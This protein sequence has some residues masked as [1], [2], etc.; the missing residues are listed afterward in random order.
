MEKVIEWDSQGHVRI[1][2]LSS[3]RSVIIVWTLRIATSWIYL[4]NDFLLSNFEL[5]F[6]N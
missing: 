4:K 3:A 2:V 6:I 5:L 1:K